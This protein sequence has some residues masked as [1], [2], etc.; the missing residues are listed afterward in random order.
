MTIQVVSFDDIKPQ[1]WRNGGG[2]TR[3][4]LAW[5]D[6]DNWL[7]RLSVADIER[8]GPFSA[9]PGIDRWFAVLTGHGV[10]L[11]TPGRAIQSG[12]SPL[13][14]DGASAPDCKLIDAP[15]RDLNLMIRRGS[16]S[17]WMRRF[18]SGVQWQLPPDAQPEPYVS[19]GIRGV[20]ALDGCELRCDGDGRITVPAMSVAWTT[21]VHGSEPWFISHGETSHTTFAFQCTRLVDGENHNG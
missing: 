6:A 17:G 16:A 21:D 2:V 18:E 8:D 20:F 19:I 9:F 7:M 10:Q 13:H 4:L 12:E 3:E 1:P 5:P 15:T 14:F 11:G